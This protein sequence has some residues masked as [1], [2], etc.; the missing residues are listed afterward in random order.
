MVLPSVAHVAPEYRHC[1][2]LLVAFLVI[3]FAVPVALGVLKA[4]AS[5]DDPPLSSGLRDCAASGAVDGC[6]ALPYLVVK[7]LEDRV[8]F[9]KVGTNYASGSCGRDGLG[10][11]PGIVGVGGEAPV[12]TATIL[13]QGRMVLINMTMLQPKFSDSTR[14]AVHFAFDMVRLNSFATFFDV[15]LIDPQNFPAQ[16]NSPSA[17]LK[18][19][20]FGARLAPDMLTNSMLYQQFDLQKAIVPDHTRFWGFPWDRKTHTKV[21]WDLQPGLPLNFLKWNLDAGH[22]NLPT[23]F[24]LEINVIESRVRTL[25]P[26]SVV[27]QLQ[28]TFAALGGLLAMSG[29]IFYGV[30]VRKYPSSPEEQ[31]SGVLTLRHW[32]EKSRPTNAEPL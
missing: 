11:Q 14:T 15:G 21:E 6:L 32:Q 25:T 26:V 16:S 10:N 29:T 2:R 12:P 23:C 22:G 18:A 8:T 7:T 24:A 19:W 30:F 4:V 27:A 31:L 20:Q 28:H 9:T 17:L 13:D 5:V 1:A 3:V